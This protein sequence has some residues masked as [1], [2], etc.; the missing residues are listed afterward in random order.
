MKDKVTTGA[1]K[2]IKDITVTLSVYSDIVDKVVVK[3]A[4]TNEEGEYSFF[5]NKL[6]TTTDSTA[7]YGV[8]ATSS[9]N[10]KFST[11][12]IKFLATAYTADITALYEIVDGIVKEA[13]SDKALS[14]IKVTAYDGTKVFGEY[15]TD[16]VGK[17]EYPNKAGVTF[18]AVDPNGAYTFADEFT[19]SSINAKENTVVIKVKANDGSSADKLPLA[20]VT[21]NFLKEK[22]VVKTATSDAKGN[23]SV[24]I[25]SSA[26]DDVKAVD[27]NTAYGAMTF[28]D[29]STDAIYADQKVYSG[30]YANGDVVSRVVVTYEMSKGDA[31]STQ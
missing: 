2:P 16:K 26:Y 28:G 25:A 18:K 7:K 24:I 15:T 19:T 6:D 11:T 29:L 10:Y 20:G 9:G 13:T 1:A 23:A 27:G 3:T 31:Y 17:F 30:F 5:V 14:G 8:V 12:A 4:V 22:K 21:V